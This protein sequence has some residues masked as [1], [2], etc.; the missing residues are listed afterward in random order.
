MENSLLEPEHDS[1]RKVQVTSHKCMKV[2]AKIS[3]NKAG[4]SYFR[5]KM[6]SD[7]PP[8][9]MQNRSDSKSSWNLLRAITRL[10]KRLQIYNQSMPPSTPPWC[11][12]V[13][14]PTML[15]KVQ[16]KTTPRVYS[17]VKAH[18]TFAQISPSVH[19]CNIASQTPPTMMQD[20]PSLHETVQNTPHTNSLDQGT[21]SQKGTQVARYGTVPTYYQQYPIL[22][23][24]SIASR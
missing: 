22:N 17:L 16:P 24:Y 7:H 3:H 13:P 4:Q 8:Q 15:S 10:L 5:R 21:C 6:L 11:R 2:S 18:P 23:E 20:S 19:L 12:L 1:R 14:P 9:I